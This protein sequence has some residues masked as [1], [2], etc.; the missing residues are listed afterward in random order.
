MVS[1]PALF[2]L[3]SLSGV[4]GGQVPIINRAVEVVPS[5]RTL[6]EF[7]GGPQVVPNTTTPGKLRVVEN[8]GICGK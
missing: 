2:T 5:N 3:L 1:F 7:L 8:S 6:S 4:L